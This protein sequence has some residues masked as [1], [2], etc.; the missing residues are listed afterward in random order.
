MEKPWMT[1]L[2]SI[3]RATHSMMLGIKAFDLLMALDFAAWGEKLQQSQ[4]NRCKQ[5]TSNL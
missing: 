1:H 3:C 5:R 2:K 4:K